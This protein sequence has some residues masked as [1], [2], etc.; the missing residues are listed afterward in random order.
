MSDRDRPLQFIFAGKSHPRDDGGKRFIQDIM[1]FCKREDVRMRM[2]F[3]E[4]Y[5]MNVARYLVQGVDVWLNTP[6]RP[7]EA[8]G[9]SG[10]KGPINGAINLS[11]LDGW[12]V[13]C[14]H[15]NPKSGWAIGT[16]QEYNNDEYQDH[17]DAESLFELLEK[18]VI[19]EFYERG[20]DNLP[21]KWIA[22][23]KESIRS[24]CSMFNTS[25]MVQQY[26]EMFYI[27]ASDLC[28]KL[29]TEHGDGAKKLAKWKDRVVDDW[30]KVW[31]FDVKAN[32]EEPMR[33]GSTLEVEAQVSLGPLMPDEVSVE[34]YHGPLDAGGEIVQA[35]HTPMVLVSTAERKSPEFPIHTY[36]GKITPQVTGQQGFAVR[37]LPKYPNIEL[38]MEPGL[39]RWS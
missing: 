31:I 34:L 35:R 32:N 17:M 39:I 36:R 28:V 6:R 23:M 5:D 4:D 11:I 3:I 24:C 16:D 26:A 29:L 2:V 30:S 8:S 33:S 12:W 25:R 20:A 14:Y 21:R 7:M 27:P 13:E 10:M 22:R 38:R 1:T 37:A 18:E 9:T 19:P 15:D